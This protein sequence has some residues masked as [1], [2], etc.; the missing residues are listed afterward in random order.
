M[1]D[2]PKWPV[3]ILAS[4]RSGSTALGNK[5]SDI[6]PDVKFICE[7]TYPLDKMAHKLKNISTFYKT[8]PKYVIKIIVFDISKY[9]DEMFNYWN[10]DQCFK[11]KIKRDDFIA[12]VASQYIARIRRKWHFDKSTFFEQDYV[13]I[14]EAEII[15]V[16]RGL[17]NSDKL[18]DTFQT[19]ITVR[20]EDLNLDNTI[21]RESVKPINY[22]DILDSVASILNR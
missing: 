19:D 3:L 22:H 4:P 10:S 9:P 8:N 16:I 17:Q 15:D 14:D 1:I 18:L 13:H 12:R 11:I 6:S 7:P 20:Y 2:I 21:S 5:I